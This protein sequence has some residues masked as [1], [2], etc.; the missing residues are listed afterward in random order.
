[1]QEFSFNQ[2]KE[3]IMKDIIDDWMEEDFTIGEMLI[4]GMLYPTII[5]ALAILLG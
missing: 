2:T 3:T 5:I 4:Y 1:M